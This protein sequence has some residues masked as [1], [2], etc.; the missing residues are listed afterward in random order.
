[1]KKIARTLGSFNTE[2]QPLIDE[3]NKKEGAI[4]KYASSATMGRIRGMIPHGKY[5][6]GKSKACMFVDMKGDLQGITSQLNG[7]YFYIS[8]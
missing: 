8:F 5:N 1:M 3:I 7:W 4:S 2:F 6:S